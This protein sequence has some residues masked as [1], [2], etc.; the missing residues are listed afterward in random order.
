MSYMANGKQYI[1][2]V[3]QRRQLLGRVP[4]VQPAGVGDAADEPAAAVTLS[5][6]AGSDLL[7]G[8]TLGNRQWK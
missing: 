1:I 8:L 7:F 5:R 6:L 2:V 3:D 4:G